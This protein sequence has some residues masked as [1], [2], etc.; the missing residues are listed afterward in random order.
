MTYHRT[1]GKGGTRNSPKERHPKLPT[2]ANKS[3]SKG[4]SRTPSTGKVVNN[5]SAKGGNARFSGGY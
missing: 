1:A 2:S 5:P 4:H 3:T